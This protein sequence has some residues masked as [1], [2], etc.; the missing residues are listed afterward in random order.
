MLLS[1]LI[2]LLLAINFYLVHRSNRKR[3]YGV[4][5]AW[6]SSVLTAMFTLYALYI[7]YPSHPVLTDSA[8][9]TA[10][11]SSSDYA[12]Q[13]DS[14]AFQRTKLEEEAR[15]NS[16]SPA[17]TILTKAV[18]IQYIIGILSALYGLIAIKGRKKFYFVCCSGYVLGFSLLFIVQGIV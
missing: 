7:F 1:L 16:L 12:A 9:E 15:I 13:S 4:Y 8:A 14:Y 11:I 5:P 6:I 2:I 18:V 17:L 3:K 10:D